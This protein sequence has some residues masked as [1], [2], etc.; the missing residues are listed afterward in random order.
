MGE[1]IAIFYEK[2]AVYNPIMTEGE[3]AH[4]IGRVL[5]EDNC[6]NNNNYGNFSRVE[7]E[8]NLKYP[9]QLMM[10]KRPHPPIHPTQKPVA[11]FEY[12]INTFSNENAIVLDNASGSGTTAIACKNT[13]RRWICIEKENK[14]CELSTIRISNHTTQ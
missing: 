9:R 3:P 4:S 13:S 5:G 2:P 14:Y 7:R 11:M 6:K 8:G 10:Y 12:L 1:E